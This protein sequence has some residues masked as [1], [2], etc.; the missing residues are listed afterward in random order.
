MAPSMAWR[1]MGWGGVGCG[2]VGWGVGG[3]GGGGGG[4]GD[5]GGGTPHHTHHVRLELYFGQPMR[6]LQ[7]VLWE[8]TDV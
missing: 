6:A 2:V 5:G 1:H 7:I 4:G 8:F 3:G